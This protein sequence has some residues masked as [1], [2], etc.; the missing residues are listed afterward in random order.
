[1]K[2]KFINIISISSIMF[3]LVLLAGIASATTTSTYRTATIKIQSNKVAK[4]TCVGI[5]TGTQYGAD[6]PI[7][8]EG[9]LVN[10]EP[11]STHGWH[12]HSS[13]VMNQ[14]CWIAGGHYNP[15]NKTHGLPDSPVRHVGDYG[16]FD[17]DAY[18]M[19]NFIFNDSGSSLYGEYAITT[20][21][22]VIN[23]GEDD[24]VNGGNAGSLWVGSSRIA[25]GNFEVK[26]V[27]THVT[28]P[29]SPASCDGQEI[30]CLREGETL[31]KIS[32]DY[33]LD[34]IQLAIED[35][36]PQYAHNFDTIYPG[37]KVCIPES[38]YPS[39]KPAVCDGELL[40]KVGAGDTLYKLAM[41]NGFSLADLIAA[42][43][44]LGPNFDLIFPHDEVCKPTDC[45]DWVEGV[46]EAEYEEQIKFEC[47]VEYNKA[48]EGVTVDVATEYGNSVVNDGYSSK[49]SNLEDIESSGSSMVASIVLVLGAV[50]MFVI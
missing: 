31:F 50:A 13:S 46:A 8:Y 24:L 36:N 41:A 34:L 38:C 23:E 30:N 5:I 7:V 22:I 10:L 49:S 21:A 6:A 9:S 18:G 26:D 17:A 14:D 1:M 35:A 37:D 25:C 16:N 39:R 20:Q 44:Q 2:K 33:M 32:K 12:V 29:R 40:T 27:V 19:A 42:N 11:N 45:G 43:S 28:G 15:F 3:S 4:S 48:V 47:V